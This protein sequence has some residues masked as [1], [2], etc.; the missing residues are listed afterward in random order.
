MGLDKMS[1][2]QVS[3][4]E[5][6]W[7]FWSETMSSLLEMKKCFKTIQSRDRPATDKDATDWQDSCDKAAYYIK[8]HLSEE[9]MRRVSGVDNPYVLWSTLR[10]FFE[11]TGMKRNIKLIS[12]LINV[13]SNWPG[14]FESIAEI[15]RLKTE[16]TTKFKFEEDDF[17]V[18]YL[19][20]ALPSD[21]ESIRAALSVKDKLTL[22][23]LKTHMTNE[24]FR[25]STA[26]LASMASK[27][28]HCLICSKTNHVTEQC[29]KRYREPGSND[30]RQSSNYG[31]R[32][33]RYNKPNAPNKNKQPAY[34]NN[35]EQSDQPTK[36]QQAK[37]PEQKLSA[38]YVGEGPDELNHMTSGTGTPWYIDS[39]AT[40]HVI[41]SA[42]HFNHLAERSD[43]VLKAA[44]GSNL[45]VAGVGEAEIKFSTV[46]LVMPGV[47]YSPD[48][49]GNY[50]SVSRLVKNGY[51]IRFHIEDGKSI[52]QAFAD[53]QLIFKA[54]E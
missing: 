51:D 3:F 22:E 1:K 32:N 2:H 30:Q 11:G 40:N 27:S 23:D 29:Y 53:D 34:Q 28:K 33:N 49:N 6:N 8:I 4:T 10:G 14:V 5:H 36:Q 47:T 43:M 41:T 44:N 52:A 21:F 26:G 39:G 12:R 35:N 42:S 54:R 37:P 17:W 24:G 48:L 45:G 15:E 7:N 20:D 25:Q 31:N 46:K 50:L 16:F 19:L 13:R 9:M 18:A 38:M